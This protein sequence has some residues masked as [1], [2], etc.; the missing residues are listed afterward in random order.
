V[1]ERLA[2]VNPR[3]AGLQQERSAKP[4]HVGK[5]VYPDHPTREKLRL[6]VLAELRS[7]P[8]ICARQE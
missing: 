3:K 1:F 4:T 5:A 7:Q 2:A 8:V 6:E